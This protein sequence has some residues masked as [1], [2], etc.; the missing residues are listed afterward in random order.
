MTSCAHEVP[1]V[2]LLRVKNGW[3]S[4]Q[5]EKGENNDLTIIS[6]LYAHPYT[7]KKTHVKSQN[8]RYKA[9]R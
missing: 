1:T 9:V 2:Y 6:K 5:R 7:V 8:D 3:L 4:L